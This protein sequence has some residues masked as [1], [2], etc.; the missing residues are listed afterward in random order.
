MS[1][2]ENF[3]RGDFDLCP[4]NKINTSINDYN[5]TSYRIE[6]DSEFLDLVSENRNLRF[7]DGN[8]MNSKLVDVDSKIKNEIEQTHDK[9][10]RQVNIRNF[11]AS[12]NL[13]KG[14]SVPTL[15]HVL[16][17]GESTSA[18]GGIREIMYKKTPLNYSTTNMINGNNM[19]LNKWDNQLI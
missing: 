18:C 11:V 7:T 16:Q 2:F 14:E 6:A 10:K 9:E 12:P 4:S 1:K 3:T 8:G 19:A 17:S 13:G 15:E 5:M